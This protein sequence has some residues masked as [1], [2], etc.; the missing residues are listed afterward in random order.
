MRHPFAVDLAEREPG[1]HVVARGL[2]SIPDDVVEEVVDGGAGVVADL[3]GRISVVRH[4]GM[5]DL[6][7]DDVVLPTEVGVEVLHR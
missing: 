1:D 6:R 7:P 4:L 2:P 5:A 3:A